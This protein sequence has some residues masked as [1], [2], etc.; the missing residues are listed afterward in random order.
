MFPPQ[1][2]EPSSLQAAHLCKPGTTTFVAY[3]VLGTQFQSCLHVMVFQASEISTEHKHQLK[4]LQ[5]ADI[6][7]PAPGISSHT[8]QH[9]TDRFA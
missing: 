2:Q 8:Q 1:T 6:K 5:Q 9:S 4:R 3:K 7:S